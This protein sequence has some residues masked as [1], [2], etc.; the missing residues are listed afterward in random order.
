[1]THQHQLIPDQA[2]SERPPETPV[3]V[4]RIV[5]VLDE[6]VHIVEIVRRG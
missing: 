3:I 6:T 2:T 4:E 5:D 1:M